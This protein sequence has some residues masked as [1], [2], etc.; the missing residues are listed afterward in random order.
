MKYAFSSTAHYSED[1]LW[2]DGEEDYKGEESKQNGQ[3]KGEGM[4]KL[5]ALHTPPEM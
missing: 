1:K 3:N 5:P 4:E 2:N